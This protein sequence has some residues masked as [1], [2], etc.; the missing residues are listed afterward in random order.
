[1]EHE[2]TT[3]SGNSTV[4]AGQSYTLTCTVVADFPHITTWFGLNGFPLSNDSLAG[5]IVGQPTIDGLATRLTLTFVTVT[6]SQ[7]GQYSCFS[8]IDFPASTIFS[9][10]DLFVTSK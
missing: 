6:T 1:M 5:V 2:V 8:V 7:A 9:V 3:T 4:Y 10:Q